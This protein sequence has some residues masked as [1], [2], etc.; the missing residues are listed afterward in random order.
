MGQYYKQFAGSFEANS[1]LHPNYSTAPLVLNQLKHNL[2]S[3]TVTNS[4]SKHYLTKIYNVK[5]LCTTHYQS[6]YGKE[7]NLFYRTHGSTMVARM[8]RDLVSWVLVVEVPQIEIE[9]LP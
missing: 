5:L 4:K 7:F 3:K 9:N 6:I 2:M 1:L 8:D